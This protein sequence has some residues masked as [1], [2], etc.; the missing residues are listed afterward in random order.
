MRPEAR[1]QAAIDILSLWTA[2]ET[3]MDGVLAAWGRAHRF[4][5]A[6]D[7]AAIATRVYAVLRNYG[8]LLWR[9]GSNA[10]R[11]LV[12][13]SLAEEGVPLASIQS[14]FSGARY[15]PA[16]L[17]PE[18]RSL[19]T[20]EPKPLP[21]WARDNYPFWLE[22]Q[23]REAFGAAFEMEMAALSLRAP[24]DLRANLLNATR[25]EAMAALAEA[26]FEP[27]PC[28]YAPSGIRLAAG[29]PVSRSA[30]YREG[31]VEIQDEGAQ[32][33]SRLCGARPGMRVIDLA[34]GA[35]GKALALAADMAN[36]GRILACDVDARRLGALTRRARRA[37]VSIIAPLLLRENDA[38]GGGD[39][40]LAPYAAWA[41]LVVVDVPCSGSGTWRRAPDLKWRLSAER[42]SAYERLQGRLLSQAAGL[43]A[44][45]GRLSYITCSVLRGENE[46][47]IEAFCAAFP[48]FRL[49][50]PH[51]LLKEAGLT[52]AQQGG[53][54]GIR[55]SPARHG[56]DG[57]F[58]ACLERGQG[59]DASRQRMVS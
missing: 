56:T 8:A 21:A 23:L 38:S 54:P 37:D 25:Q 14:L 1:L 50:S 47:Q 51:T 42:L 26:G 10:P 12:L 9:M 46:A 22:P 55:L 43:V 16:P 18:E 53:G 52:L 6:K 30:P 44:P 28:P 13:G 7:R 20:A 58:I 17:T 27:E 19:L 5:G 29:S 2:G 24:L 35:G 57:F 48:E 59:V 3:P 31:M 4:A 15:G 11:L 33:A 36:R 40:S 34:A 41:D 45:G 49:I 32:V 39:Q